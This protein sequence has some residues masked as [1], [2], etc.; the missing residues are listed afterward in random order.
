MSVL[1]VRTCSDAMF[2][3]VDKKQRVTRVKFADA[4]DG[5]P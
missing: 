4:N 2:A 3:M 5:E 1:T